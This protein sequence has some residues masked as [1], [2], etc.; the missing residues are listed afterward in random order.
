MAVEMYCGLEISIDG[1]SLL[2]DGVDGRGDD[3][4]RQASRFM[5]FIY[6][7]F[8]FFYIRYKVRAILEAKAI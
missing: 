2:F 5:E 1:F 6:F 7:L 8:F 3:T 4:S